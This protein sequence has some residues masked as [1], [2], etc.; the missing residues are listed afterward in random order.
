MSMHNTKISMHFTAGVAYGYYLLKSWPWYGSNQK[1]KQDRSLAQLFENHS[2]KN[3][4][5]FQFWREK[6]RHFHI[7]KYYSLLLESTGSHP[8]FWLGKALISLKLHEMINSYYIRKILTGLSLK[9]WYT[10]VIYFLMDC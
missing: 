6:V 4:V 2:K 1:C 7:F 8:Y 5:H 10:L 9:W 3:F